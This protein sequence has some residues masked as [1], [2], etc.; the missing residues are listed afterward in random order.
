MQE[1]DAEM[2]ADR[3]QRADQ[4]KVAEVN[5]MSFE[6]E[7]RKDYGEFLDMKLHMKGKFEYDRKTMLIKS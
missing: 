1:R 5:W 4:I 7:G 3:S 2:A 6:K